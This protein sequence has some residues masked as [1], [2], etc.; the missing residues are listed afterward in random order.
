VH[1]I[2]SLEIFFEPRT[3]SNYEAGL[4]K[5]GVNFIEEDKQIDI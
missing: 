1:D 3:T 2:L 4:S 5:L